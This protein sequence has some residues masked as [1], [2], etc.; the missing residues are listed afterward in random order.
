MVARWYGTFTDGDRIRRRVALA[1][2]T[3]PQRVALAGQ[4]ADIWRF[5]ETRQFG[6]RDVF[7]SFILSYGV[8][9]KTENELLAGER[10][11]LDSKQL[12]RIGNG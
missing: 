10:V 7:R 9:V 3:A 5:E 1:W 4:P 6:G 12:G 2:V 11:I 8:H